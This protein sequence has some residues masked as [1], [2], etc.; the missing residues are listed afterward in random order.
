MSTTADKIRALPWKGN[1][2][3]DIIKGCSLEPSLDNSLSGQADRLIANEPDPNEAWEA[4]KA[5]HLCMMGI[6]LGDEGKEEWLAN[7]E[8]DRG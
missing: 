7:R 4:E 1:A 5:A 2:W 8:A 3:D 6:E